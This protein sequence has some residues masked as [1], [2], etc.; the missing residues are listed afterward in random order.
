[1]LGSLLQR[2][3]Y[4]RRLANTTTKPESPNK[5]SLGSAAPSDASAIGE[6]PAKLD[7]AAVAA[8]KHSGSCHQSRKA[9]TPF[10]LDGRTIDS[11]SKDIDGEEH[12]N[13]AQ[14]EAGSE[15]GPDDECLS[16]GSSCTE[17]I[18]YKYIYDRCFQERIQKAP[19]RVRQFADYIK[20]ME[21]RMEAMEEQLL[22][23][24][25]KAVQ[26]A[27]GTD[28]DS[29]NLPSLDLQVPNQL[30]LGIAHLKWKDF[31]SVDSK[32]HVINVL[33]GD[34]DHF[35]TP[36]QEK[37]VTL[38]N[39]EK[40]DI[41]VFREK[42]KHRLDSSKDAAL[43][44]NTGL[45]LTLRRSIMPERISINSDLLIKILSKITG[46][47]LQGPLTILSP[48]KILLHWENEIRDHLS[49]LEIRWERT[50]PEDMNLW[51]SVADENW[52]IPNATTGVENDDEGVMSSSVTDQ[53]DSRPEECTDPSTTGTRVEANLTGLYV[54]R[55]TL[56]NN[57]VQKDALGEN[58]QETE[59]VPA[60]MRLRLLV[61]FMDEQIFE[62]LARLKSRV[63]N[64]AV[65]FA[66]LY[67][68][69]PPGEEVVRGSTSLF[70]GGSQ[71]F[72]VLH[73][74]GGRR[75]NNAKFQKEEDESLRFKPRESCSPLF[76]SCVRMD[77]DGKV[78][79]PITHTFTI[80][81]YEGMQSVKLLPIIPW[82]WSVYA[83]KDRPML[84]HRG[85]R[86]LNLIQ[87]GHQEY[88][89]LALEPRE[90]VDS[91][92][93]IDFDTTFEHK[94]EWMPSFDV[95]IPLTYDAR[96]TANDMSVGG[97]ETTKRLILDCK[98][99]HT[100]WIHKDGP[101]DQ[102][103]M[104]SYIDKASIFRKG[105][106]E[107]SQLEE[108]DRI[109]L[110]GRVFG[111]VLRSR[112]WAALNMNFIKDRTP[113][114]DG[115]EHLI[116]PD[117]HTE[118]IKAL[119]HTHSQERFS[120]TP[121]NECNESGVSKNVMPKFDLVKGKGK[122]L[123]ILCHGAPGVGKTSTAECIADSTDRPLFPITC[124]DVGETA[125]MVEMNLAKHFELA[126]KWGCVTLLDEAD[127]FMQARSRGAAND[128]QRNSIVSGICSSSTLT[129][130]LR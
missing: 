63:D 41:D 2:H 88:A 51:N 62:R 101:I 22:S 97:N 71:V 96:E 42:L 106:L 85:T 10:G 24:N 46:L 47:E 105:G 69:Y 67:H 102:I 11:G 99:N 45:S 16:E 83:V 30:L 125:A 57:A 14:P 115:F 37:S 95:K 33:V 36:P 54:D 40:V 58:L 82:A 121:S 23:L 29:Q 111:Y 5:A 119:V 8:G 110:P 17:E 87:G 59:G 7:T 61:R 56:R 35:D 49:A 60:L 129:R 116:L 9:S 124:G 128:I 93:I 78:L 118:L 75:Y 107:L 120:T 70:S 53:K 31:I 81:E 44:D 108:N 123:I 114:P 64:Q 39:G 20:L 66:D 117:G 122:G 6:G 52:S 84:Q 113:K 3:I 43:N 104:H 4:V 1:M 18:N 100:C 68:L 28:S 48:F 25:P 91:Q 86:F 94:P 73:C 12:S 76:V 15:L 79:A 19:K 130:L 26:P 74:T 103:R 112:G 34:P 13:L 126:H 109:L 27:A 65:Y 89:G 55:Y 50:N 32:N 38:M 90:D 127:V 98:E 21:D 92:I 72:R 77:F 80:E